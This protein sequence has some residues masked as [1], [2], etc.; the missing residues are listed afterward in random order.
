MTLERVAAGEAAVAERAVSVARARRRAR[1]PADHGPSALA[2]DPRRFV[3]LTWTLAVQEFKLR[4]FGSVLG[5]LWQLMRP[6]MLFG[7]LYVVFTQFVD[8]GDHP[9]LPGVAAARAS[10]C[11]RSSPRRRRAR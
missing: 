6:L 8:I 9:L 10:C 2:G 1:P 3:H 11:S 7:V 4:F 5:Y